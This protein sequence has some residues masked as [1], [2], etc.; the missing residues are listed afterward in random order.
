MSQI[1]YMMFS[2][3]VSGYGGEN[4][5]GYMASMFHLFTH[6]MFKAL[7]F[8]GAGAV[9][10]YVHSNEMNDMGGLRKKMPITH[11]TF[12][13][14]CLAI[15]GVP[16][17]AGFFS[18]EE[19]LMAAFHSKPVIFYLAIATATIT[20]FYMFRL[21]FSIFWKKEFHAHHDSKDGHHGEGGLSM[22]LPLLILGILSIGAGFIPF[23]KFVTSDGSVLHTEMHLTFSIAPVLLAVGGI[24]LAA[25]YYMKENA[26]ADRFTAAIKGLYTA[27]YRKFYI[28]ELY[29]F[30]TKK[31]IFRYLGTPAEWIDRNIVNGM[32]DASAGA[33]EGISDETRNLQSGKIQD[34]AIYFFAC[35]VGTV[36]LFI[37]LIT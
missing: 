5:L 25:L 15:A 4:G 19:I 3:G 14:A 31:I 37:Y 8:L 17:F 36:L 35:A 11:I 9:I 10:H 28:D 16:P 26:R 20:A 7:L 30:V 18:K 22:M 21:Y 12:L 2:L 1:G 13:I 27:A 24:S 33:A 34:Y 6:A 23:G 29:L 32:I